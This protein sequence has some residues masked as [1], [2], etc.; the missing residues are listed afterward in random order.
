LRR[1]FS[2][3]TSKAVMHRAHCPIWYVP[4]DSVPLSEQMQSDVG[5]P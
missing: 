1:W 3:D 5:H 4:A 2:R